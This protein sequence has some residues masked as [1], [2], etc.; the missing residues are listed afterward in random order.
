VVLGKNL[1]KEGVKQEWKSRW[2]AFRDKNVRKEWLGEQWMA[3]DRW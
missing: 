2:Q 1:R 3:G